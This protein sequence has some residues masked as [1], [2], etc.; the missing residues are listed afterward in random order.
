MRSCGRTSMPRRRGRTVLVTFEVVRPYRGRRAAAEGEPGSA[1]GVDASSSRN[2]R[3]RN[4]HACARRSSR[5]GASTEELKAS[6]EELQA[7]N[8]ELRSATEELET[9]KEE[10]QSINEELITVNY[11]L[12]Q[13]VEETGEIND[14]LQN[15]IASTDIATVFV[16]RAMRIK[17]YTPRAA[18]AVQPDRRATSA[19]R[20]STSRT[21]STTTHLADDAEPSPSRTL[22]VDR[23]RG[24]QHATAAGSWSRLLPYRTAEDRIDGAVLTFIDITDRRARRA[25]AAVE[26]AAPAAGRRKHERLRDRHARPRRSSS[27]S[28]NPGAER[29][30]GYAEEE[31]VGQ[32]LDH[33]L[34]RRRPRTPACPKRNCGGAE[35]G[36]AEDERWHL[37]K[38]GSRFYLQRRHDAARRAAAARATPRSRA[39]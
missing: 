6:N 33:D 28:W 15:L 11:E 7:I 12:K 24:A 13:K 25:A 23:A 20:C 30:F 4:G 10:L 35:E 1:A 34:H 31:I 8:E 27:R 37:R 26:D 39:T 14:D 2:E 22:R 3:R 21:G 19:A 9:S 29:V 18:R 38:D 17:R 36:R 32:P 16:D 5:S